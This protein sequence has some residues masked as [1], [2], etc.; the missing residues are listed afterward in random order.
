MKTTLRHCDSENAFDVAQW[1]L[2]Q[3]TTGGSD[4]RSVTVLV[5]IQPRTRACFTEH[6]IHITLPLPLSKK[7]AIMNSNG[8]SQ[9]TAYRRLAV[10]QVFST[11]HLA[12]RI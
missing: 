7:G 10:V 8:S 12:R 4:R 9:Y 6:K 5:N 2:P 3:G 11:R 1:P